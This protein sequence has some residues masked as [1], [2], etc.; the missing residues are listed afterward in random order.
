MTRAESVGRDLGG[1]EAI[2]SDRPEG[3]FRTLTRQQRS[4]IA[5]GMQCTGVV[6]KAIVYP[7]GIKQT[8]QSN[9]IR[10]LFNFKGKHDKLQ[11]KNWAEVQ[12]PIRETVIS[13]LDLENKAHP[14]HDQVLRNFSSLRIEWKVTAPNMQ[15]AEICLQR[16]LAEYG[17]TGNGHETEKVLTYLKKVCGLEIVL[18]PFACIFHGWMSALQDFRQL[19]NSTTVANRQHQLIEENDKTKRS[20][21]QIGN[22]LG[23]RSNC[24]KQMRILENPSDFTSSVLKAI[25]HVVRIYP[26]KTGW[27]AWWYSTGKTIE[28]ETVLEICV[29]IANIER[30]NMKKRK[31][32]SQAADQKH[33][34]CLPWGTRLP[35]MWGTWPQSMTEDDEEERTKVLV[36]FEDEMNKVKFSTG[37]EVKK[38]LNLEILWATL[39]VPKRRHSYSTSGN[40]ALLEHQEE[41]QALKSLVHEF[42]RTH[43]VCQEAENILRVSR[44]KRGEEEKVM[45]KDLLT[46][47]AQDMLKE[48]FTDDEFFKDRWWTTIT[49]PALHV[50]TRAAVALPEPARGQKTCLNCL[51]KNFNRSKK[52][53][54]CQTEF[55]V[56]GVGSVA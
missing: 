4:D 30:T 5:S 55:G 56:G 10:R 18:V 31:I 21:L 12:R 16:H 36:I 15:Q 23:L 25:A 19:V 1:A 38:Q 24:P 17:I 20:L 7:S 48:L 45:L 37:D 9:K 46:N 44:L 51:A 2:F 13:I 3:S 39:R 50:Q 8:A 32:L 11:R 29:T 52:C 54:R 43:H 41:M 42:K 26:G 47:Y 27:Q 34:H 14:N 6:S 35:T 28:R 33:L 40:E 22:Q 53:T 49:F